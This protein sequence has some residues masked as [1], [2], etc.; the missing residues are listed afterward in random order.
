M[1][2]RARDGR[3][4]PAA[5]DRQA[6]RTLHQA[7][8]TRPYNHPVL[9]PFGYGL[10]GAHRQAEQRPSVVPGVNTGRGSGDCALSTPPPFADTRLKLYRNCS[11]RHPRGGRQRRIRHGTMRLTVTT[12]NINSVR[13]RI[14]LVAKFVKAAR[15][16]VL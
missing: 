3:G 5:S 16:D 4:S 12:W 15:P 13:L 6:R 2:H 9:E 7:A 8:R 14:D 10:A 11:P 1:P